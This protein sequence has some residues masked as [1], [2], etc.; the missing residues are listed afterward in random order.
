[1]RFLIDGY[2]L[3]HALGLARPRSWNQLERSRAD[4]LD[5]LLRIHETPR[6]V[7]VVFDGKTGGDSSHM[8]YRELNVHFST[9]ESADDL[10]EAMIQVEQKPAQVTVV[11]SDRRIWER[12][13]RRGCTA[14]LSDE[15]IEW[16]TN[17]GNPRPASHRPAEKPGAISNEEL[18]AWRETFADVENDPELRRNNKPFEDFG[19]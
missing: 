3:M 5:W 18:R 8:T 9:G 16:A 14:W 15:Y 4:L 19:T 11:S 1:M 7:T 12:A 17:R 13:T 10:I 2:N 6:D